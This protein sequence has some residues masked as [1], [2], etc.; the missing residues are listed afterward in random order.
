[1]RKMQIFFRE[2]ACLFPAKPQR[3]EGLFIEKLFVGFASLGLGVKKPTLFAGAA[4]GQMARG[5]A[6]QQPR[7]D[8]AQRRQPNI[9][10][11]PEGQE[12]A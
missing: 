5:G 12:E 6:K 1:M 8:A 11:H 4:S 3:P 10:R 7:H 2:G 9:D